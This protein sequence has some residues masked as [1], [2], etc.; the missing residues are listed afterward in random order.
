MREATPPKNDCAICKQAAVQRSQVTPI[1]RV[2]G[3]AALQLPEMAEHARCEKCGILMGPGH[4]EAAGNSMCGTCQCRG[5]AT[6]APLTLEQRRSA[7]GR[8]GWHSDYPTER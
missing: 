1:E 8:R 6:S 3:K 2:P 4:I 7:I 5:T